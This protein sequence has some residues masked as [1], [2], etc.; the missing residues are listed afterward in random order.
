MN[1]SI[2]GF[3]YE[4]SPLHTIV[5]GGTGTGKTYF[6]RH[7]LKLFLD[8][9]SGYTDQNQNQ[10]QNQNQDQDLRSSSTDQAKNIILVCKDDRDWIDPETG[11]FFIGINTCD[12]NMIT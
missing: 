5:H 3:E 11:E 8:P 12:I 4:R 10:N 2:V 7:Y 6:I 1:R 9:R